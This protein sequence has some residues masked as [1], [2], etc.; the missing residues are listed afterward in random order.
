MYRLNPIGHAL[1][2][3]LKS[4]LVKNTPRVFFPVSVSPKWS[5]SG[6]ASFCL[7]GC[8]LVDNPSFSFVI[9][10]FYLLRILRVHLLLVLLIKFPL[11]W[12]PRPLLL[13]WGR[14]Q[15]VRIWCRFLLTNPG[16]GCEE[17]SLQILL[18]EHA[19]RTFVKFKLCESGLSYS[20]RVRTF[21]RVEFVKPR[22]CTLLIA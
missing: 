7:S 3:L 1:E 14:A 4:P 22:F 21:Q 2:V 10:Q 11:A 15:F 9:F 17:D 5:W 20:W 6:D 18:N 13:L 19:H 12:Q 8:S 16:L